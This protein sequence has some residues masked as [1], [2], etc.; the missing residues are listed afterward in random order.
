[1]TTVCG[2]CCLDDTALAGESGQALPLHSTK[3][4]DMT[5][6]LVVLISV[7]CFASASDAR[8]RAVVDANGNPATGV[9][10]SKKTGASA[11]VSPQYAAAFQGYIDDLESA[12]ASVRFMGGIRRGRCWAGSLHPCGKALDVCQTARGRVDGRCHLP[13]RSAVAKIAER[14]GLFEGGRWCHSDYGHA[15]VGETAAACGSTLSARRGGKTVKAG[16]DNQIDWGH[17]PANGY[18]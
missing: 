5:R 1:M 2:K 16:L 7:V 11:R 13:G 9:V 3:G 8:Q 6:I 18:Y 15:Q 10:V 12:G 14:H 17:S 4:N